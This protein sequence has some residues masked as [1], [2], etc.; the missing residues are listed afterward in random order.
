MLT[1]K[2]EYIFEISSLGPSE[3]VG[4]KEEVIVPRV[5]NSNSAFCVTA[6]TDSKIGCTTSGY[7]GKKQ[8]VTIFHIVSL[9][10]VSSSLTPATIFLVL[11]NTLVLTSKIRSLAI[12]RREIK[13]AIYITSIIIILLMHTFESD[14][15]AP[16]RIL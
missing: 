14:R 6:S 3:G 15:F 8:S 9:T 5:F 10:F 12:L 1:C 16:N 4:D 13:E 2:P 11:R 7:C